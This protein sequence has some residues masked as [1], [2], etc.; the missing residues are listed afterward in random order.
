MLP[1]RRPFSSRP[2]PGKRL[3]SRKHERAKARKGTTT[4]THRAQRTRSG[5]GGRSVTPWHWL[6][7]SILRRVSV[8]SVL[9][10]SLWLISFL[11]SS[12]FALSLFRA[13]VLFDRRTGSQSF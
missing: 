4:E 13:F 6:I 10:V 5:N 12:P 1:A 7:R 3:L 11:S 8:F 2:G 9:S